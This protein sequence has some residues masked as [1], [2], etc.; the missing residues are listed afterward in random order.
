VR[1]LKSGALL[2]VVNDHPKDRTNMTAM[3][4]ND[5][6]ITWPHKLLLDDRPGVTYP[7]AVEGTNGFLYII[8]DHGRYAKGEQEI[9]FAKI[10][11]VDIAAG[12]LVNEG[13]RLRQVVNRLADE[14]GGVRMT[15]E[16]RKMQQE[17]EK[18]RAT[19]K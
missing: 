12:K 18:S 13:S 19:K 11:E 14:G 8:Y 2:M 5:D 6:G 15:N 17:F 16:S 3:L 9:L 10:T 1:R 4:S 7:D